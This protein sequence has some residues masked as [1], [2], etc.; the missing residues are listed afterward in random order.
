[1]PKPRGGNRHVQ[2]IRDLWIQYSK[3]QKIYDEKCK[4]KKDGGDVGWLGYAVVGG[5]ILWKVA[6]VIIGGAVGGPV[7]ALA[8]GIL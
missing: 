5:V 1:M 4:C 3:C 2:D 8:G 6:K 7:G